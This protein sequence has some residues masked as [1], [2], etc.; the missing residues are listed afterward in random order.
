MFE[1]VDDSFELWLD[2]TKIANIIHPTRILLVGPDRRLLTAPVNPSDTDGINA[3]LTLA[4]KT[5]KAGS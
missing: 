4:I 2:G 5:A 3:M 1:G